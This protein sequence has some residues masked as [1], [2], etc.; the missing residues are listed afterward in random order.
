MAANTSNALKQL[1]EG[2]GL[3]LAAYRDAAGHDEEDGTRPYVVITEGIAT[4]PDGRSD[5]G[6]GETCTEECQVSLFE[7]WKDEDGN[8]IESPTLIHQL[9]A[10][11]HGAQL[12]TAPQRVYG[13]T[14]I[15]RRRLLEPSRSI[16]HNPITV[17]VHRSII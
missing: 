14:V 16:V 5:G 10:L 13:V 3:T 4:V 2:G 9:V 11:L 8:V 17:N 1:I 6:D 12:D 7:P 15:N